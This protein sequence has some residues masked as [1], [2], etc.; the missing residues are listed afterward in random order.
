MSHCMAMDPRSTSVELSLAE[1]LLTKIASNK[2]RNVN[3][4]PHEQVTPHRRQIPIAPHD[5]AAQKI[6]FFKVISVPFPWRAGNFTSS[7][8]TRILKA[9]SNPKKLYIR[10]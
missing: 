8:A 10:T 4:N 6:T 7:S 3:M 2:L 1:N 9:G 5:I